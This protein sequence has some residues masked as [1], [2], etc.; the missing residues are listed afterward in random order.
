[1]GLHLLAGKRPSKIDINSGITME[2]I[3]VDKEA[4]VHL[5]PALVRVLFYEPP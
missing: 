4:R 3:A 1:M 5:K 2:N